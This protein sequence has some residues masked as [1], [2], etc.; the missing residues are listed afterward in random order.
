MVRNANNYP[1]IQ[2]LWRYFSGAP[3]III[4]FND[5]CAWGVTNAGRDVKDYYEIKFRDTTMQEYWYNGSMDENHVQKRSTYKVK[6]NT[7]VTE[8]IAMTVFGPV[9]Y[10]Q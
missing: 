2:C 9:M 7:D 1:D 4:G 10:D 5:S 6:G 8:H 3:S